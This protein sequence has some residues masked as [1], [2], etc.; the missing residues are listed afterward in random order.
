MLP[1]VYIAFFSLRRVALKMMCNAVFLTHTHCHCA[2]CVYFPCGPDSSRLWPTSDV[3]LAQTFASGCWQD[4]GPER[5]QQASGDLYSNHTPHS[6][7]LCSS[8]DH[9]KVRRGKSHVE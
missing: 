7:N 3:D 8:P 9:N 1:Y 6:T 2:C 5:R 4:F